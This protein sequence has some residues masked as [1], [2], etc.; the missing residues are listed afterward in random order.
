M[1]EKKWS[2]IAHGGA[3]EL[4]EDKRP[5]CKQGVR[6]A[7]EAGA[8]ILEE[9][10]SALDAVEAAVLVLENDMA[11]NAG[12]GSSKRKDGEIEMDASI[13][14]GK[15]LDIGAVAAIRNVKNPVKAARALLPEVPILLVGEH[16]TAFA[17]KKGLEEMESPA[18]GSGGGC[19]D[20]VGCVAYD[21]HGNIAVAVSTGGLEDAEPGRVGDT[22][23]PG[24][25]FYADNAR[26][27]LCLSGEGENIARVMLAGEIMT[28][29]EQ[30]SSF[31]A[32]EMSLQRLKRVNGEAGCILIDR[33]GK[34]EWSH[35]SM[36]FPV[37]VQTSRDVEPKVF[38]TKEEQ[39]NAQ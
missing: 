35:N 3:K 18:E 34:P 2:I 9:G 24:C 1:S 30:A 14:D 5:A 22:A 6:R 25:G 19:H 29:L 16:A 27:G 39:L 20:T 33:E 13:M 11:F 10:G 7:V 26:G 15:S 12:R 17:R 37:C 23:L 4:E 31:E 28:T 36:H 8:K 32:I 21:Y 38:L